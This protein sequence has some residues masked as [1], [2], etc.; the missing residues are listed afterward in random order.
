LLLVCYEGFSAALIIPR[1]YA[2]EGASISINPLERTAH[3]AGF[4]PVR[5]S[6]AVGRRSPGAFGVVLIPNKQTKRRDGMA[7]VI[8][9][10]TTGQTTVL[11]TAAVTAF[12]TR[13]R[14]VLLSP[15][16][17]GYDA[18]RKVWNGNIDRRPTLIARCTGV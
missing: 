17:D 14:G 12:K 11:D 16:A 1:R 2:G 18:A 5:G 7:D 3:S 6:V 15:G 10:T 9:T 8:A 4:V 13:L